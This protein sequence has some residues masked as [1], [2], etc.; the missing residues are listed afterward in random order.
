MKI[1]YHCYG[2]AHSSVTAASIHL[3]LLPMDY[4]PDRHM[5]WRIPLYDRQDVDEHGH[6][7]FMGVDE[8]GNEVYLTAR[9]SWPVV[10]EK[11]FEGLAGIFNIPKEDYLFVNVMEKVNLT[12]KFGGFISRRWGFIKLGRP[13]VTLGTQAAYFRVVELVREIKSRVGRD[14]EK[15]S[16]LQRQQVASGRT[17]RSDT[18]GTPDGGGK[19]GQKPVMGPAVFEYKRRGR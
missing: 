18:Y 8:Y 12:M 4:I 16:V 5:F 19:A 7:F 15:D 13:I 6:I 3:G 10:L 9:R 14:S 2:G 1:I 11:V 17:G